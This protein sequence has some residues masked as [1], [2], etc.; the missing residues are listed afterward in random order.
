MIWLKL[1]VYCLLVE[2]I[3]V[4]TIFGSKPVALQL[5][6]FLS[7]H[8]LACLALAV[9]I[10]PLMAEQNPVTRRRLWFFFFGIGFFI[11]VFGMLGILISLLC[12]KYLLKSGGR[13][14]FST[15]ALPPF[16]VESGGPGP[17]MGE[18]GAWSR[19]KAV[20]IPRQLRL[21]ALLA[22]SAGSGQNAS[23]LLQ[24]ASGDS[25]E[26]IRL[27]AFNLYDRRE[28]VISNSI[29]QALV[30]LG[31]AA[32]PEDKREQCRNLAFSYW[33]MVYNDLARDELADFF[34][35]QSLSYASQAME[36]GDQDSGLLVL[37]GRLYLRKGEV[38]PAG[39][40][41]SAALEQG[42]HRDKVIPYLAELAY[43]RR[44]FAQLKD[45]FRTD[46]LLRHK[47]GIGPVVQ[48]WMG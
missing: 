26:E 42:I 17:G 46:P 45:Y 47:P 39:R 19:I 3:A 28:K 20:D 18:G 44:D 25:D 35:N 32:T 48:F 11:P 16:M 31:K 27:L 13:T 5:L 1:T 8:G 36:L 40:A 4:L 2:L 10:T 14:E 41:I 9:F 29:N 6:L 24:L 43:R 37:I 21:K 30:A 38:E 22:I 12:Y 34:V 33:E 23:R 7:V 15:V